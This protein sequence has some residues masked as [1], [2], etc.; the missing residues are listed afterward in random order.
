MT[1]GRRRGPRGVQLSGLQGRRKGRGKVGEAKVFKVK[2]KQS[3]TGRG[4]GLGS[5][6][7]HKLFAKELKLRTKTLLYIHNEVQGKKGGC[8]FD[9]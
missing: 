2:V 7:N 4:Q 3:R 9:P 6:V 1:A 8:A 5:R